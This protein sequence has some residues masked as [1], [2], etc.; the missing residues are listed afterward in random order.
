MEEF[1]DD[2]LNHK[3]RFYSILLYQ[4]SIVLPIE[5]QTKS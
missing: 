2:I 4:Y 3:N 5:R 1:F